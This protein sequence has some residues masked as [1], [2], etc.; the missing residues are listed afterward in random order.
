M[1]GGSPQLGGPGQSALV[2]PPLLAPLGVGSRGGLGAKG[3][4]SDPNSSD[5]PSCSM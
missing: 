4:H 2:A 3:K 1:L 5:V